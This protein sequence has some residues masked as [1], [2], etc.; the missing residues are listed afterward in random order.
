MKKETKQFL[1]TMWI[2]VGKDM[3]KWL[4]VIGVFC[5]VAFGVN[6]C[7]KKREAK[8]TSNTFVNQHKINASFFNPF[9]SKTR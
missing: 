1:K 2:M 9:T 3:V 5:G 4:A 8:G 6:A 7:D